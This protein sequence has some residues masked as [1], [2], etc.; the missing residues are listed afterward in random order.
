MPAKRVLA[1]QLTGIDRMSQTP[2]AKDPTT[3]TAAASP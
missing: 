2:G 1:K 3:A